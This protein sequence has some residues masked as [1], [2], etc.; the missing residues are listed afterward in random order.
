MNVQTHFQTNTQMSSI[1]V[2]SKMLY[3]KVARDKS[4]EEEVEV[5]NIQSEAEGGG[6][7]IFIPSLKRERDTE[8]SRLSPI[9]EKKNKI[10]NF[11][12]KPQLELPARCESTILTQGFTLKDAIIKTTKKHSGITG[13]ELI[14]HG[15]RWDSSGHNQPTEITGPLSVSS[16]TIMGRVLVN[17]SKELY[18][19]TDNLHQADEVLLDNQ[20]LLFNQLNSLKESLKVIQK[21]PVQEEREK[22]VEDTTELREELRRIKRMNA[23]LLKN[24]ETVAKELQ[25]MRE[26]MA[27]M[28]EML[29]SK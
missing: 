1:K 29:G 10:D 26:E 16:Q 12:G 11:F 27:M 8:L 5:V 6:V 2:G 17:I 21:K 24:Q 23:I 3:C 19:E 4:T 28:R 20:R 25:E 22:P 14:V 18:A 13:D 15:V 7:T 9:V